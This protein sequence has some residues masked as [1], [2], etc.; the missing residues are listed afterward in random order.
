M[1]R[2]KPSWAR[3]IVKFRRVACNM[4]AFLRRRAAARDI[5][6][7]SNWA[8]F[9]PRDRGYRLLSRDSLAGS[10]GVVEVCRELFEAKGG[11]QSFQMGKKP[12]FTNVLEAAD[13]EAR[14][15]LLDS[16][17]SDPVIESVTGYLGTVPRLNSVGLFVS[18]ANESMESSQLFHLDGEDFRMVK[19]FY[20]LD[21]VAPENGPFTFLPRDASRRVRKGLKVETDE[22]RHEDGDVF[23]FCDAEE[24]I[25]LTG[26]A[27][28]GAFV[29]TANFLHFG[30]R[31][32]AGYRMV[33]MFCYCPYPN[34]K[35]DKG[36]FDL[37][38]MP[39]R[40]FPV[41][42]YAHDP[43]RRMILGLDD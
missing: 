31:A 34:V 12:F 38:G 20:N 4:G 30:S 39:V 18:N 35:I 7:T 37:P 13:L 16:I 41:Q 25:C 6:G 21:H 8:H 28:Q 40:N 24:A 5:R 14:P 9:I 1:A 19:C 42:R 17:L 10:G 43:L 33:L 27:G 22:G 36:K 2:I 3:R 29:D 26:P 23:Q 15:E 32:R 11:I